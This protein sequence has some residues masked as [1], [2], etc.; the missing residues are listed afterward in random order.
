MMLTNGAVNLKELI[1][2]PAKQYVSLKKAVDINEFERRKVYIHDTAMA[3]SEPQKGIAEI[4]KSL[5]EL[6]KGKSLIVWDADSNSIE[7]AKSKYMR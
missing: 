4:N 6:T 2:M 7:R 3:F 5:N 1:K